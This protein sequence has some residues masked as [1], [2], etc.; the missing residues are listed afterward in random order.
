MEQSS[1]V[2][3]GAQKRV[4]TESDLEQ[5]C[6]ACFGSWE[7]LSEIIYKTR[8]CQASLAVAA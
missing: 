2:E 1:H 8:I 5:I 7:V 4:Q 3:R 6:F